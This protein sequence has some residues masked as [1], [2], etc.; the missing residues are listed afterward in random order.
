[1][2]LVKG[3]PHVRKGPIFKVFLPKENPFSMQLDDVLWDIDRNKKGH[4][5]LNIKIQYIGV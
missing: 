1:M 2:S 5:F 3:S 4:L